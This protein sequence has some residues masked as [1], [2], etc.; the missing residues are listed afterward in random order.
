MHPTANAQ[1]FPDV[2]YLGTDPGDT[3]RLDSKDSKG[4]Q[5]DLELITA[6]EVK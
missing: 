2:L 6:R 5:W 4:N 3:P 1:D